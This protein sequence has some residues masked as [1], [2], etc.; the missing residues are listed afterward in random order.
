[1]QGDQ[2]VIPVCSRTCKAQG[3]C[4]PQTQRGKGYSW[5]PWRHP[6]CG[7][8]S[9]RILSLFCMS[10]FS[11]SAHLSPPPHTPANPN[12]LKGLC[13]ELFRWYYAY[14]F[15]KLLGYIKSPL[16]P[17]ECHQSLSLCDP[18]MVGLYDLPIKRLVLSGTYNS[19]ST[20]VSTLM[21]GGTGMPST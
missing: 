5:C 13:G 7:S 16:R 3:V 12:G 10:L 15:S 8:V 17:L 19:L 14:K 11:V 1:M 9:E 18:P 20:N 4:T 6:S 2:S 21:A